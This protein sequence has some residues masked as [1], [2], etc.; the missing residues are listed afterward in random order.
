MRKFIAALLAAGLLFSSGIAT[1][2]QESRPLVVFAAASLTDAM[3][4]IATAFTKETGIP[5]KPSFAASSALAKQIESGA[6]ADVFFPADEEWMDYL[7]KKEML[8]PG[9]RHDVLANR[10]VLI[11]PADSTA[12]VKISSGPA[13]VK[14][15]GDARVATGDPDSVPVGKYAKAALTKLGAWDALEPRMVRAE[16][17]RAAL[18]YV[19]RGEAPFGIVYLTDA[20]IEKKVKLLDTFP[21]ASHPPILYPIALTAKAKADANAQKFEHYMGSPTATAAFR[22]YGFSLAAI[23]A[24]AADP[25][26]TFTWDVSHEFTVMKQKPQTVTAATKPG[27]DTPQLLVDKL[28][29]VR[30]ANQSGVTFALTPARLPLPDNAQA[31]VAHFHTNKAGRYRVAIT[32]G[33]W[34]DILDGDKL[35]KSRDFQRARGCER[36]HKIVEYD[37]PA[38]R[39][40]TLQLSGSPDATVVLAVTAVA[41]TPAG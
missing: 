6:P 5:I 26:T 30:L 41:G 23:A 4:E 27:S 3:T 1:A 38:G 19:A 8:A 40:L 17:V 22:K 28:Y 33:H 18:A 35:I 21:A 7:E 12:R 32:S 31:G 25:C 24:A 2:A 14:A 9:T 37:L 39:E 34:I 29:E 10:L 16:N 36:P 11:A 20:Q 13:L 15:I